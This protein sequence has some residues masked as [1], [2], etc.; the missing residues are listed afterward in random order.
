MFVF[1]IALAQTAGAAESTCTQKLV[2]GTEPPATTSYIYPRVP[3]QPFYQWES[4]DGYCGEVSMMEAGMN[5]GQWM[6]QYNARLICGTGLSQSGPNGACA[7]HQGQVNYN[8]QL[9]IETPGT[10]V[11]G[12]NTYANAAMATHVTNFTASSSTFIT[13]VTTTSDRIV[14]FRAVPANA[15]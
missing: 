3:V 1:S 10:G 12:N 11:T 9:L 4:N 13:T 5:N 6:S 14:V 8:A 15:P 7:K 2:D